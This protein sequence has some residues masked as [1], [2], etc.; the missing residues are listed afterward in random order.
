MSTYKEK[1]ENFPRDFSIPVV[2]DN[3]SDIDIDD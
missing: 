3:N 2:S 1:F